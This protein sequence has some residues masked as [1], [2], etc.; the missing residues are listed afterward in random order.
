MAT[1]SELLVHKYPSNNASNTLQM[2]NNS[3]CNTGF[4]GVYITIY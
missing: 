4:A 3:L 2:P 1:A